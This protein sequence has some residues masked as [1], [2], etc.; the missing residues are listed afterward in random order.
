ME[1][2]RVAVSLQH[3]ALE[4][5]I[6]QDAGNAAPCGE[7]ADMAAQKVLHAGVEKEAQKDLPGMTEHHDERHQRAPGTT[8]LDMAKVRPID[9]ALFAGQAA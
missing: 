3:G 2:N 9:L 4:I 7:R 8:D 6:E 5:V 1:S